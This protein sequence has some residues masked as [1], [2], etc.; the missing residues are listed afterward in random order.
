MTTT[1]LDDRPRPAAPE[2]DGD[3]TRRR[4]VTGGV[5]AGLFGLAGCGRDRSRTAS[6][7]GP[8]TW[9]FTDDRG[10]TIELPTRPTRVAAYTAAGAAMVALGARPVAIFGGAPLAGDPLLEGLDLRGVDSAGE[11]YGEVNV[12]KLAALGVDLV[13]TAYDPL[14]DGPVFGFVDGPVQANVE[15]VA[16]IVAFNGIEAPGAVIGRFEDLAAALDTDLSA[17]AVDADRQRYA[18]ARESLRRAAAAKPGLVAVAVG[19]FDANAYFKRP[20]SSP[21][22]RQFRELGLPLVEPDGA[23]SDINEDFSGYFS[24]EV[25]LEQLGKYPADLVLLDRTDPAALAGIATWDALPAVKAGQVATYS[26]LIH[27]TYGRQA[28][29]LEAIAAAVR[30]ADPDLV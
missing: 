9:T 30:D 20:D 2:V 5:A 3:I 7:G 14:Q 22:T 24:E 21:A 13:V 19:V 15:R 12:E 29:E 11:V 23:P 1:L 28:A 17:P 25:S 26:A 16:P 10:I 27:W 18:Q 6:P 4:F 8:S